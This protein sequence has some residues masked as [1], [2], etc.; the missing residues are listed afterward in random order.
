MNEFIEQFL[1]E[2]RELIA[3]ATGDLMA[4]EQQSDDPER[5]DSVF[6]AFHTLKGAAGIVEFEPMG[7]ALHAAESVLALLRSHANSVSPAIIDEC[8]ACLDQVARW[9]NDMEVTGEVPGDAG[10][11]ADAIVRR[12]AEPTIDDREQGS[13]P[14]DEDWVGRLR[15]GNPEAFSQA[16]TA[17]RY[18]ADAEAFF[19]G[20]DP[21]ALIQKLPGLIAIDLASSGPSQPFDEINP[22][23]CAIE[24]AALSSA[25]T[26][27]VTRVFG[28]VSDQVEVLAVT[29]QA[30]R[31]SDYVISPTAR[32]IL[33][34]QV[35]LLR[36]PDQRGRV[37]RTASAGRVSINVLRHAGLTAAAASLERILDHAPSEGD[38]GA[39]VAAI[40]RVF[41]VKPLETPDQRPEPVRMPT[42]AAAR[43]LRVDTARIDA[44]VNLTGELTVVKN[45]LGHLANLAQKGFDA[46]AVATGLLDQQSQLDRLVAE[47]QRAVLRIR[48]LPMRQVFQRFPRLVREISASVG[49]S[50]KFVIEGDDTEADTAIVESLFE[51]L[52]H[53][54]RNAV[55]HGIEASAERTASGKDATAR[56][57]LRASRHLD[58]VII[59]I[60]DDGRGVDVARVR[61]V[62]AARGVL[63]AGALAD[64]ADTDVVNLIFAPGFSTAK[65]VTDLSGRGVGMDAVRAAVERL[66]GRVSIESRPKLGATVRLTLPF[67]VMMTRVMTVEAGSQ[68]FGLPLDMVVETA[69]IARDRIVPIGRAAAFAWRDK[70]VPLVN[71]VESLGLT[72]QPAKTG[73]AR[74]VITSAGGRFGA[75]EVD[76]LGERMDV[77][78]KPM[79][80]LL[81][82]LKGVAGTTLLGDGRVL[83]VLDVQELFI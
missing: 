27:A 17:V 80:G 75:V 38:G 81:G 59:E 56:V 70:T 34:A 69:M 73:Q 41:Q 4:L 48:V 71:L 3:Q 18:T 72:A 45:A 55:D 11:A 65:E 43:V 60:E 24:I 37:G 46:K 21:L 10:A 7:R 74:V 30:D 62:A 54:L 19:R 40:E 52:L 77:M 68:V 22:F 36:E 12:F 42:P 57:V 23:T 61:E 5:L 78:L 8:L 53:V 51:P 31:A 15:D 50:I 66:G 1:I 20:E 14:H 9:L 6:R 29:V 47:V 16:W 44:L 2:A 76:R 35:L 33:E 83:I 58:N 79:Q 13:V 63:E 39:I 26:E 28:E 32:S 67:T 25:D 64:M 82:D 49:K